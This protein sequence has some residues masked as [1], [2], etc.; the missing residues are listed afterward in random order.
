MWR[1][2]YKQTFI[3]FQAEHVFAVNFGWPCLVANMRPRRPRSLPEQV[4]ESEILPR[5]PAQSLLRFRSVSKSCNSII[6]QYCS[7]PDFVK[8]HLSCTSQNPDDENLIMIKH[9]PSNNAAGHCDISVHSFS[10]SKERILGDLVNLVPYP[11]KFN[12]TLIGSVNGLVCLFLGELCKF[13]IWNPAIRQA[14]MIDAPFQEMKLLMFYG[15]G[16]DAVANDYK[17]V[18]SFFERRYYVYSCNSNRWTLLTNLSSFPPN[19]EC[20][21]PSVI[22][23]G[24]PYWTT[25]QYNYEDTTT[26]FLPFKFEVGSN[27]FK[28]LPK[29]ECEDGFLLVNLN[30]CIS[31]LMYKTYSSECSVDVYCLDDSCGVWRKMYNVGPINCYAEELSHCFAYGGQIVFNTEEEVVCYDPKTNQIKGLG[32]TKGELIKCYSYK[33]SLVYLE[34]MKPVHQV[35]KSSKGTKRARVK[36]TDRPRKSARTRNKNPKYLS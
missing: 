20:S 15:F 33:A 10:D 17:L 16:W 4:I 6:S 25:A 9:I 27:E 28:C 24:V 22:V 32:N 19:D 2:V 35:A 26:Y 36:S 13:V 3:G 1:A 29:F 34:G 11:T 21:M 23:K 7:D 12:T 14:K 18:M 31:A 8:S 5:L 30:E